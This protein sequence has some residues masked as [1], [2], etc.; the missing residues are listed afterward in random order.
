MIASSIYGLSHEHKINYMLG[1]RFE[2]QAP[3]PPER[4]LG[5]WGAWVAYP[6]GFSHGMKRVLHVEKIL[7]MIVALCV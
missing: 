6:R 3:K 4:F 7:N 2:P 5:P 1:L